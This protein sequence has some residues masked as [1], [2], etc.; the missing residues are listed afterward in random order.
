MQDCQGSLGV[1]G[2][3]A[4]QFQGQQIVFSAEVG[5]QDRFDF[6]FDSAIDEDGDVA[7]AGG[8]DAMDGSAENRLAEDGF[9]ESHE[10]QIGSPHAGDAGDVAGN[11]AADEGDR[12][13]GDFQFFGG[14]EQGFQNIGAF[15]GG[16]GGTHGIRIAVGEAL[17]MKGDDPPA[18][19]DG[20]GKRR[21]HGREWAAAGG[22]GDGNEH[23]ERASPG[24]FARRLRLRI[25]RRDGRG[26]GSGSSMRW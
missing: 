5:D 12:L 6:M 26:A 7:V 25:P 17:E 23:R 9:V 20:W 24:S 11:I 14:G 8:H 13:G 18:G 1:A 19:F 16:V 3:S 4:G 22:Q 2:D 10:N 21:G 15:G